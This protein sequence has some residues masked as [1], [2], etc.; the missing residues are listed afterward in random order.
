MSTTPSGIGG[1]FGEGEVAAL[2]AGEDLL[3]SDSIP[4]ENQK[5]S[6]FSCDSS[7]VGIYCHK[8][9]QRND[10]YRRSIFALGI[11]VFTSIFSLENRIWRTWLSLII[12][13]GRAAREFSDGK[14][15]KWTSP[16]RIYLAMSIILF[17]YLSL[18]E[19]R[20]FSVRTDIVPKTGIAGNV[21]DLGDQSVK[22]KPIFGFFRRQAELDVLNADA[23]FDRIARLMEGT[24][25]QVFVYDGN[26]VSLGL[27]PSDDELKSYNVWPEPTSPNTDGSLED[28]PVGVG[29]DENRLS[30][31]SA[32]SEKIEDAV[33]VYNDILALTEDPAT[34]I[35][36]IRA[37]EDE[38]TPFDLI[39]NFNGA[40]DEA[41][42]TS[43][44]EALTI[45]DTELKS[46]GLSRSS[47]HGL[48]VDTGRNFSI[49]IG[50]GSMNGVT[51]TQ[52][53][54]QRFF[55]R[56]LRDPALLNE[57]VSRYLPRIMFLMMPFAA[58]IGMIF[59]RGREN[60]LLYDHLVHAAYI[61]AV[62]FGFM[63]A[64]ILLSQ[65]TALTASTNVFMIGILIYLPLSAKGMFARGW[66][67]TLLA[68][69]G[70][71]LM[72]GLVMFLVV[73]LLSA[74]SMSEAIRLSRL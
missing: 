7:L 71:A 16:V 49:N 28:T 58:I 42:R 13:P 12:R 3:Q 70:I 10:D 22:L 72:Y 67:K 65:W 8:C 68:S 46:L 60:A 62:T 47:F 33:E 27:S 57:G 18:T 4:D 45:L 63:L 14:R 5:T 66:F 41:G 34:V 35:D 55:V 9:G 43:S 2:L 17:G 26:L 30:A 23:D 21:E 44:I 11:E 25:K 15:T 51:L 39:A 1:S 31:L 53:D 37:K 20:I 59:I 48:P 6:C 64:L 56:V 36:K 52:D 74:Q 73:V 50:A 32:Y 29:E 40:M 61:H 24:P 69:Y 54:T 19:T 38:V